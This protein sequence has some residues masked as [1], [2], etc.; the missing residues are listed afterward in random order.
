[1]TEAEIR[2]K[3]D[4]PPPH[5]G[6]YAL[7]VRYAP[8]RDEVVLVL[9][10]HVTLAIPRIAVSELRD[11][12]K[13]QLKRIELFPGGDAVAVEAAD[14]HISV[15]GLVRDMI[16]LDRARPAVHPKSRARRKASAG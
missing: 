12:S 9:D 8:S 16:G 15:R 14:V 10:T 2:R 13:S 5:V 6:P 1:M 4:N 11:L 7:S 3:L